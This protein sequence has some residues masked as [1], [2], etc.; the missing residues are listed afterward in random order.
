MSMT[1]EEADSDFPDDK[2]IEEEILRELKSL[3][4]RENDVTDSEEL[5]VEGSDFIPDTDG[6]VIDR[7][8]EYYKKLVRKNE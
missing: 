6:M 4:A 8:S 1:Y 3:D 7:F 5:E 2:W